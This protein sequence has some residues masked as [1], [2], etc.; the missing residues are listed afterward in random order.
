[1][2]LGVGKNWNCN[3]KRSH[4]FADG[5][6][7]ELLVDIGMIMGDRDGIE[8]ITHIS[9]TDQNSCFDK[10]QAVCGDYDEFVT[11][12]DKPPPYL[13]GGSGSIPANTESEFSLCF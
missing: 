9:I 8:G 7:L 4:V 3:V 13:Q 10:I 6:L 5:E 11:R 2:V 1:M 12:Y